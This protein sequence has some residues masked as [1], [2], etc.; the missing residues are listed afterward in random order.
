MIL[1]R[2]VD[3]DNDCN[4]KIWI[5]WNQNR[6]DRLSYIINEL[7]HFVFRRNAIARFDFTENIEKNESRTYFMERGGKSNNVYF[8]LFLGMVEPYFTDITAI[9]I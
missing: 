3:I 6:K 2:K 5:N 7:R 1:F 9:F 4:F 8:V